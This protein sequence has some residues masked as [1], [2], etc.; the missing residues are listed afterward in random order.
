[1]FKFQ[2]LIILLLCWTAPAW[3]KPTADFVSYNPQAGET[4]APVAPS[5]KTKVLTLSVPVPDMPGCHWR[6][7]YRIKKYNQPQIL[8]PGAFLTY[9]MRCENPSASGGVE[10]ESLPRMYFMM[11]NAVKQGD[12]GNRRIAD[13]W[14]SRRVN[15]ASCAG[16]PFQHALLGDE[17][18]IT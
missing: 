5:G 18:L 6:I 9:D 8:P 16:K 15:L 10:L 13:G 11:R 4:P 17:F 3:C 7:Y 1:M 2:A 14:I 12:I